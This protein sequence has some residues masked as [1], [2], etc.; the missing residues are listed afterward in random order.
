MK[1]R[2]LRLA[3]CLGTLFFSLGSAAALP[4]G[5]METPY[6]RWS[7]HLVAHQPDTMLPQI[8]DWQPKRTAIHETFFSRDVADL[9]KDIVD[10]G[11]LKDLY[12]SRWTIPGMG[13]RTRIGLRG[14]QAPSATPVP[15]PATLLLLGVGLIGSAAIF[16]KKPKQ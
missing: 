2:I 15:E 11:R 9:L 5:E 16:R 13:G 10:S 12:A 7:G 4:L 6:F 14:N 8:S 1:E 3:I